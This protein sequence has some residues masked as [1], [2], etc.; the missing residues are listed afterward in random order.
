M[1]SMV[2][3]GHYAHR[4]SIVIDRGARTRRRAEAAARFTSGM[5]GMTRQRA[6]ARRRSARIAPETALPMDV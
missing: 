6:I 5:V 1:H 3:G 4:A 2:R